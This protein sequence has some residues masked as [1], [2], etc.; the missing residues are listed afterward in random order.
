MDKREEHLYTEAASMAHF[1]KLNESIEVENALRVRF[2][3]LA[4]FS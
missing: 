3:L 4:T 1:N 2:L